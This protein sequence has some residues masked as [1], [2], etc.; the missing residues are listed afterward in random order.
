[1]RTSCR[2]VVA[3]LA[4]AGLL[5]LTGCSGDDSGSAGAAPGTTG[6]ATTAPTVSSST[7]APAPSATCTPAAG[8]PPGTSTHHLTVAGADREFLVH[9]PPQPRAA[10]ALLVDF[11]GAGSN[12]QQQAIYSGFDGIAD[13][14]GFVVATPNGIDAAV[15]QWRFLGT[16]D[17]VDFA[18]AIVAELVAN[19]CVDARYVYAAGI[20]SGAAM[21]ASLA[22]QASGTF[23]GFGLVAADFYVP[24]LCDAAERRHIVIFH[25]TDDQVV[26]YDGGSVSGGPTRV[27]PAEESAKLWAKHNGCTSGPRETNVDTEVVRLDWSGCK[28]PVVM[29]RIVGGGHTWPG[30]SVDVTRLGKTTH[31]I[32]AS[33]T[34]WKFLDGGD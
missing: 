21:S 30:A 29:Y 15:R 10:M 25:G 19:A 8:Y 16:Q 12:M 33:E 26:P 4:V 20:S 18:E 31:Q 22:C 17:D 7:T 1:M 24:Q 23:R 32:N 13:R 6:R 34:M 9:L 5:A 2:N 11:H 27:Q 28:A 3:V 14:E